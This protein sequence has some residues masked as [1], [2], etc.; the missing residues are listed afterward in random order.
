MYIVY[1]TTNL[2]NG[3]FYIGVHKTDDPNESSYLG[4][5]KLLLQAIEKYGRL[6]FKR[7]T[8]FSFHE[9][10]DA[11]EKEKELLTEELLHS[12]QCYNLKR[13]GLG[14][15]R[16]VHENGL[17]NKNKTREHYVDMG[18]KMHGKYA[19]DQ[20]YQQRWRASLKRGPPSEETKSKISKTLKGR[21]RN[22]FWI[23]N[24]NEN[25]FHCANL[26]IEEGFWKGRV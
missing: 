7:E 22:R 6:Q 19:G 17:T 2:V 23:T 15:W 20:E 3:K 10:L 11:F 8:L 24:G 18:K 26:P 25:R 5:G 4:S 21:K 12:E 13:G 14:G 1:K 9:S 16:Y